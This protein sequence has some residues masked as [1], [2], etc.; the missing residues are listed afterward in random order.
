MLGNLAVAEP[1]SRYKDNKETNPT[2][3]AMA[4]T[5]LTNLLVGNIRRIV[6]N[7]AQNIKNLETYNYTTI[8]SI[9]AKR[10][11][12]AGAMLIYNNVS[13]LLVLLSLLKPKYITRFLNQ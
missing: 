4:K 3:Q 13:D 2:I 7:K 12:L 9:K 1:N 8:A 11:I 6:V 10:Y 5:N